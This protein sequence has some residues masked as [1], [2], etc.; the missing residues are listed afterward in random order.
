[1][2]P[3]GAIDELCPLL[4]HD[5][6][7]IAERLQGVD[8]SAVNGACTPTD[9]QSGACRVYRYSGNTAALDTLFQGSNQYDLPHGYRDSRGRALYYKR[10]DTWLGQTYCC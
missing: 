6:E 1:E 5:V 2:D 4:F 8:G 9:F 10:I 7:Q 3:T